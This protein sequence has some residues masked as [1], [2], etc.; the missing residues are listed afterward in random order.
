MAQKSRSHEH[1]GNVAIGYVRVGTEEQATEGVSLDAQRAKVLAYCALHGLELAQTYADG[2]WSG[3]MA[4]WSG[5]ATSEQATRMVNEHL[6]NEKTLGAPFGIRSLSKMEKMYG[7]YASSNPSNWD[8][9]VWGVSNYIVF[10][11]L[12]RYGFGA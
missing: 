2:G 9:P 4:M 12:V 10:R 3:F 11:G 7:T 8:G 5:I 1:P 6:K